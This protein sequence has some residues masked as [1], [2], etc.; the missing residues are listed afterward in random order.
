MFFVSAIRTYSRGW[1]RSSSTHEPSDPPLRME[2]IRFFFILSQTSPTRSFENFLRIDFNFVFNWYSGGRSGDQFS[3]PRTELC[4]S[5]SLSVPEIGS[6]AGSYS[7]VDYIFRGTAF[8]CRVLTREYSR[9]VGRS[10]T[11]S[12]QRLFEPVP[13]LP[14]P[15]EPRDPRD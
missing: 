8:T 10:N 2:S 4:L 11:F 14:N 5:L 9:S 3:S 12:S 7:R 6:P 1:P 13:G 15:R